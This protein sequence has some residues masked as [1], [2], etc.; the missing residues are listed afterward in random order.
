MAGRDKDDEQRIV[1]QPGP[2][3]AYSVIANSDGTYCV[4]FTSP[5]GR[6]VV[7]GQFRTEEDARAWIESGST[8]PEDPA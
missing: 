2:K 7:V 1:Q 3:T 5:S 4:Q 6:L 8:L